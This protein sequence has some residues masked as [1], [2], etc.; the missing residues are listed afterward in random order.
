METFVK[1]LAIVAMVAVVAVL[2][3]IGIAIGFLKGRRP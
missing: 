2:A 1:I 3:P